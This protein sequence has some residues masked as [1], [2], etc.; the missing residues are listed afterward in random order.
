MHFET[1]T[2]LLN[3]PNIIVVS[4]LESTDG[5]LHLVVSFSDNAEPPVCS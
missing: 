4:T 3:L 5:H 1:I 2:K